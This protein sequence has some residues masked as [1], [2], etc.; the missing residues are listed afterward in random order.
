MKVYTCCIYT[1]CSKIIHCVKSYDYYIIFMLDIVQCDYTRVIMKM[2]LFGK[3][4]R[5]P[6]CIKK[7]IPKENIPNLSFNKNKNY[8]VLKV[9]Q[10]PL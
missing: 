8:G 1:P 10:K 6:F 5:S 2:A 9:F 3:I 7:A 4:V